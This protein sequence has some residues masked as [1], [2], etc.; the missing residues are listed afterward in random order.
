MAETYLIGAMS[1]DH[2][3]RYFQRAANKVVVVGGDRAE[4]ILAALETPTAAIVLTGSYV[5]EPRRPCAGRRARR[6]ASSRWRPTP[7]PAIDGIRRLFGRLGSHDKRK[8]DLI[9]QRDREQRRP[10]PSGRR[11]Q[12]LARA[13]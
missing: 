3:L 6:A 11:S 7:S 5:P 4:I 2:A 8:L 12:P 10:R 13:R 9:A 1:P